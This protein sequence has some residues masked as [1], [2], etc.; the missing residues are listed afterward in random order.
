MSK[1][2]AWLVRM[3]ALL[4]QQD[5]MFRRALALVIV[6]AWACFGQ[7]NYLP[8][9]PADD[10][11]RVKTIRGV[12]TFISTPQWE[13]SP[14]ARITDGILPIPVLIVVANDDSAC[15]VTGKVWAVAKQGDRYSCPTAWRLAR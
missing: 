11:P 3:C 10:A 12:G 1:R 8:E 15:I 13:A 2:P 6:L 7:G 4:R 9:P 5:E 14:W